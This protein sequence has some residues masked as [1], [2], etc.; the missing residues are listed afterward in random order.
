MMLKDI[1]EHWFLYAVAIFGILYVL[2]VISVFLRKAWSRAKE[3][4][5]SDEQLRNVVKMSIIGTIV[6]AFAIVVGL[7]SLSGLIG[8]PWSWFRL[9]V[10]GSV[11]YEIMAAETTLSTSNI[12]IESATAQNFIEILFVMT[13]CILGG[14]IS[15]VFLVKRINNGAI[16]LKNKDQKWGAI[17][18]SSFLVSVLFVI[19][20]PLLISNLVF[21][22]TFLTSLLITGIL[23]IFVI[24]YDMQRLKN[25][26]L[27][28]SM[29]FS[30]VMSIFYTGIVG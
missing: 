22:L 5:F 10:L 16:N 26:V 21:L 25:F 24:K 19:C 14:L 18:N 4:G 17:V 11:V 27:V 28:I 29:S 1:Y 7:I 2:F 6:P 30:M 12:A 13:I 23:G 15:S 9:S 8:I 3:L 20:I